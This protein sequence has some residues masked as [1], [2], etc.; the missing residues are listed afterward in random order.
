MTTKSPDLSDSL[1]LIK[2]RV[3]YFEWKLSVADSDD[4]VDNCLES[5]HEIMQELQCILNVQ[6]LSSRDRTTAIDYLFIVD[7]I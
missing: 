2:I 3:R 1:N 5:L 7:N 6:N 4:V